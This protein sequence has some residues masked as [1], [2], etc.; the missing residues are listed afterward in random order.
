MKTD[1]KV[2]MSQIV[3]VVVA[4]AGPFDD[5]RIGWTGTYPSNPNLFKC[6]RCGSESEDCTKIEHK[7]GCSASALLR[8][9]DALREDAA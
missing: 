1:M 9:M 2:S 3:N 6:E 7:P 8:V 5:P 4:Y